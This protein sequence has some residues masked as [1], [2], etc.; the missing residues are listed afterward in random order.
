[1]SIVISVFIIIAAAA[2]VAA[3]FVRGDAAPEPARSSAG[4]PDRQRLERQK[5]DAY[6]A[7]KEAEFDYRM[8]K[9][10]DS[11]FDAMR[12]KYAAQALDV[13]ATLESASVPPSRAL[14]EARRTVRIKHCPLCGHTVPPRAN[15][16][17]ACGRS[18]NEAVA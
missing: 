2:Y 4:K 16:C 5:S 14:A 10:S 9:L 8:G 17:P 13:I 11:G 15:F 1:M 18:L 12:E 6:A 7:I 3:P